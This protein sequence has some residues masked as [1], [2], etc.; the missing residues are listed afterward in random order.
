LRWRSCL[1][2]SLLLRSLG[3][4]ALGLVACAEPLPER[5][6]R[7]LTGAE[8][9]VLA[10]PGRSGAL[11]QFRVGSRISE[12]LPTASAGVWLAT[13]D[14]LKHL[15]IPLS[16]AGVAGSATTDSLGILD[17]IERD[18]A[19]GLLYV[20]QHPGSDPGEVTEDH[21]VL[22]WDPVARRALRTWTLD[23]LSYD[24]HLDPGR[25]ILITPLSGRRLWWVSFE[26]DEAHPID[27]PPAPGRPPRVRTE[28]SLDAGASYVRVGAIVPGS[29]DV[30]VVEQ[31]LPGGNRVWRLDPETGES[32]GFDLSR[33]CHYQ[34]G[35]LTPD[36]TTLVLNA[37]EAVQ[38]IDLRARSEAAW[39]PLDVRHFRVAVGPEGRYVY[40]TAWEPSV[41][42]G[43]ITR[44]DLGT[45]RVMEKSAVPVRAEAIVVWAG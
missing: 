44:V 37:I 4:G 17:G 35:V 13:W 18:P 24:L 2:S 19:T 41:E 22:E 15:P 38:A 43:R 27:L 26:K 6:P 8:D 31:G 32:R 12:I 5:G 10:A 20:L 36:G 29:R 11:A 16:G 14:G 25:G 21:L 1:S 30:V 45:R 33:E 40:L 39:I 42:G 9:L 23:L 3:I 28:E 7:V 34:G